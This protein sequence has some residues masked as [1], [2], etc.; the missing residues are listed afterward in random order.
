MTTPLN[1]PD[2]STL[3]ALLQYSARKYPK[4]LCLG[5]RQVG[6][7]PG[8]VRHQE[9]ILDANGLKVDPASETK[10][11]A[12]PGKW[13][14]LTYEQVQENVEAMA[15]AARQLL[16]TGNGDNLH[17]LARNSASWFT[18]SHAAALASITLVTVHPRISSSE[19]ATT[20]GDTRSVGIFVDSDFLSTTLSA[21]I[22]CPSVKTI[23]YNPVGA[24]LA[25]SDNLN[26]LIDGLCV[27]LGNG[28]IIMSFKELLDMGRLITSSPGY[29]S[30]FLP[31]PRATWGI[32]FPM[33]EHDKDVKGV[34]LTMKNMMSSIAAIH[35]LL[36]P[37]IQ[38]DD[39]YL[40]YLPLA[41]I[42]EYV[43]IN[44]FILFGIQLG[45]GTSGAKYLLPSP[46]SPIQP[47][48]LGDLPSFE[49]TIIFG[50]GPWWDEIHGIILKAVSRQLPEARETFWRGLKKKKLL[51]D[52]KVANRLGMVKKADEKAGF[53]RVREE[54][55]G[56][57]VKWVG[58]SCSMIAP[59]RR[60]FL[61]LVLGGVN[62]KMVD[63]FYLMDM[64][65]IVT[66][67]P[68]QTNN[69]QNLGHPL[70]SLE[71]KLIDHPEMNYFVNADPSRG[72]ICIRGP[73]VPMGYHGDEETS[74]PTFVCD[75][76]VMTGDI[77]EYDSKSKG[78]KV[79]DR[80][81]SLDGRG[82]GHYIPVET[83]QR[84][85]NK[86][87]VVDH[88]CIL[89]SQ[90]KVKGIAVICASPLHFS[91]TSSANTVS[92]AVDEAQLRAFGNKRLI[93][94]K[95]DID[96]LLLDKRIKSFLLQDLN[97]IGTEASLVQFQMLEN[98]ILVKEK[99]T[100]AN[101]LLDRWGRVNKEAV[102]KKYK[103]EIS[104][105]FL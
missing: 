42:H 67:T 66:F 44:V 24:D 83:M 96:Q 54:L 8:T 30:P 28:V 31:S 4:K 81:K 103:D 55:F 59:E 35:Q 70:P 14:Y 56:S 53:A 73:S 15:A 2:L 18:I 72:Q 76:W 99:F 60:E 88:C 47:D 40:S 10:V 100:H 93:L 46:F 6:L 26:G 98:L 5:S 17:L 7:G 84:V 16:G 29:L 27:G 90:R 63:G 68:P 95:A 13:E 41:H 79:V 94:G 49:P 75:G 52:S 9:A 78:L 23:I 92:K 19:L 101:G 37:S 87:P 64:C 51:L 39:K 104:H 69:C 89:F 20:I 105:A 12:R 57:K 50:I 43:L 62:G 32:H 33:G 22:E 71:M 38:K 74:T 58:I 45:F 97:R 11:N 82:Y 102:L 77:G 91:I 3:P 61:G 21:L 48:I 25:N 86:S 80:I 85:F 36:K 34:I 1:D 65:T